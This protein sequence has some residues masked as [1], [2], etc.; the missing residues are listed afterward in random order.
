MYLSSM[1]TLCKRR[2]K[3]WAVNGGNDVFSPLSM[4]QYMSI[5]L[6]RYSNGRGSFYKSP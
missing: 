5:Q 3:I 4:V 2:F 6:S 1:C